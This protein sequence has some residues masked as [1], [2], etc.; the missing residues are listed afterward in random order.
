[1]AGKTTARKSR[2]RAPLLA[3]LAIPLA[4][5]PAGAQAQPPLFAFAQI[6]DVQAKNPEELARFDQVLAAIAAAGQ[7][8][9]LLPH[10]VAAVFIAGDHVAAPRDEAQWI[11]YAQSLDAKLTANGIPFLAVPG[12]RDQDEFGT[13]LYEQHIASAGVWDVSSA[14]LRGQNG[15]VAATGWEG[16][17]FIGLNNSN[18]AWNT[19]SPAHLAQVLAI[20]T[21]A[22]AAGENVFVVAHHP[23]DDLGMVPLAEV[24][25]IPGVIGTLRGHGGLPHAS[26]D[27]EGIANPVWDL[28]S[29]SV[30]RDAALLYY[31]VFQTEIR[32][33][34][35]ALVTNP[36]TLPAP[37]ILSL[38]QALVP[39]APPSAP[40]AA[41]S[42]TPRSGRAPLEV[43]FADLSA[44]HPT[45][46]LWDFGDG[47]TSSE[48]HP[49][50]VYADGGAYDVGLVATNAQGSGSYTEVAAVELLPP[51]PSTTFTP[52]ADAR[53]VSGAPTQNFGSSP[54]LRARLDATSSVQSYL[55]FDV[56]GL[57]GRRVLRASLRLFVEDPSVQGG[58][59]T[60]APCGWDEATLTFANAPG[61]GSTLLESVGTAF[62]GTWVEF[63]VSSAVTGEGTFCFGLSSTS[64]NSVF[65][66]SREGSS[67]PELVVFT[68]SAVP[69]LGPLATALLAAVLA[70]SGSR[71]L[72]GRGSTQS[73]LDRGSASGDRI[74]G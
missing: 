3:G 47:A 1:M 26:P 50:H 18:G 23:H 4:L 38:P 30:M 17:R 8:G 72:S 51:L 41:F 33:Y 74:G 62:P 22:A 71:A 5:V 48:R 66:S 67:P 9:S 55:R 27:L 61:V 73:R 31:E 44:D 69:A 49:V 59:I 21:A 37:A 25:E 43:A 53:V 40:L 57:G 32:V 6:S 64:S 39:A 56:L 29:E 20:A 68:A 10:A 52:T 28:S 34:V 45:A 46:W 60:V 58:A 15:A 12:N 13:P 14:E 54:S 7:P 19:V 65:Y 35:L 16:L 63:D 24:L 70:A 2:A 36:V 42:A 11:Q